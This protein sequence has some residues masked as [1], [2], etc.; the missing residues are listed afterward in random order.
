M[1]N[2]RVIETES[3]MVSRDWRDGGNGVVLIK[4]Y[5]VSVILD[6]KILEI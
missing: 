2:L 6:E 1:K 5:K 3:R 4:G